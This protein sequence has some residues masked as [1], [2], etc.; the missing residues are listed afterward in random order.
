[1]EKKLQSCVSEYIKLAAE[2]GI[3]L[4]TSDFNPARQ[5]VTEKDL[6]KITGGV[7]YHSESGGPVV[8]T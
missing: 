8:R 1:M 5:A 3:T 7:T 6:E 2:Y 4:E